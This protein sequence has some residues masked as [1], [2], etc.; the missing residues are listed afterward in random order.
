MLLI[1]P[2]QKVVDYQ[3][4]SNSPTIYKAKD[5]KAFVKYW[6][7]RS[8]PKPDRLVAGNIEIQTLK[9]NPT[10][11]FSNKIEDE[12]IA[13]FDAKYKHIYSRDY[14]I[15]QCVADG[16]THREIAGMFGLGRSRVT[17]IVNKMKNKLTF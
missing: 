5:S 8:S 9:V 12:L 2:F 17:Q 4:S 7:V 15:L 3:L 11:S 16:M 13:A 6:K 1:D 10:Q 14:Q